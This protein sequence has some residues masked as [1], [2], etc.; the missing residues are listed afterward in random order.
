MYFNTACFE[1]RFKK[2]KSFF[3]GFVIPEGRGDIKVIEKF[4]KKFKLIDESYNANPASMTSAINNMNYYNLDKNHRKIVFLGDMLELGKK[5]KKIPYS[6][7][8]NN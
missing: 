6:L 3:I 5:I 2:I 4:N 7:G 1:F 8:R